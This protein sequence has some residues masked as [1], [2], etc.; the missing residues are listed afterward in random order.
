MSVLTKIINNHW[1]Q[2]HIK[3]LLFCA[4]LAVL[5]IF[6][7]HLGDKKARTINKTNK[8]IKLLE[9]E[10]KTIKSEVMFKTSQSQLIKKAVGIGLRPLTDEAY[11]IETN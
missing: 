1:M 11:K 10:Y 2:R 8:E 5:Y 7:G 3:L 4:G 9:A 6:I